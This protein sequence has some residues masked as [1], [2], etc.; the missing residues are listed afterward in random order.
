[1]RNCLLTA[2]FIIYLSTTTFAQP[3]IPGVINTTAK[4]YSQ[5]YYVLDWSVGEMSV[6]NTMFAQEQGIT[7]T[8]G[9]LQPFLFY[10]TNNHSSSLFDESEIR[11]FPNPTYNS[12]EVDF[13]SKQAGIVSLALYDANA[14]L[15]QSKKIFL[16]GFGM[17]ERLDLSHLAAGTY[18]L[19]LHLVP[20]FG[21]S[22]KKGMYKI[23]KL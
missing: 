3:E 11:I 12:T 19:K 20:V 9:F 10:S 4:S 17:M 18:F 16:S 13:L 23:V 6:I 5:G 21:S 7:L 1:M 2:C 22:F 15:I 8:N 14:K